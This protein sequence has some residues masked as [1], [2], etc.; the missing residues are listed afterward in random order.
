MFNVKYRD[1]VGHIAQITSRDQLFFFI[2]TLKIRLR[3]FTYTC[4]GYK[5]P[6]KVL[7]NVF[8][9]YFMY[10]KIQNVYTLPLIKKIRVEKTKITFDTNNLPFH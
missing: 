3:L 7:K 8:K 6:Y 4:F 9:F 5:F 2:F 10:V 1:H